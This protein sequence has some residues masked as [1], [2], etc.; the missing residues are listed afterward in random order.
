MCMLKGIRVLL[1]LYNLDQGGT[2]HLSQFLQKTNTKNR[3]GVCVYTRWVHLP[4]LFCTLERLS[5]RTQG[6]EG[7]EKALFHYRQ[8]LQAQAGILS[9]MNVAKK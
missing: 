5:S 2:D 4:L 6:V 9:F 1:F 3:V 8:L 7:C